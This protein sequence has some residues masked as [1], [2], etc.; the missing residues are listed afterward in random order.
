VSEKHVL[1]EVPAHSPAERTVALHAGKVKEPK[2]SP[3]ETLRSL[4]EP[5]HLPERSSGESRQIVDLEAQRQMRYDDEI[6]CFCECVVRS[7]SCIYYSTM[8]SL[9]FICL[10]FIGVLFRYG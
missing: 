1:F 2:S 4:R 5:E 7:C 3:Q 6:G 9:L 8:F 10:G